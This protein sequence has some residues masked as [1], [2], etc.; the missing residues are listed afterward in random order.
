MLTAQVAR[1]D[2]PIWLEGL[3]SVSAF[4]TV[5]V[6]TQISGQ[7][8]QIGF[9]EG[10]MVKAGDF[11]AQIDPRPYQTA[12]EQME[13]QLLRDQALLNNAQLDAARYRRLFQQDSVA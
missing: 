3:G 8:V 5:T 13:G 7:L 6:K 10:Q 4:Y 1:R 2:V 11:L 9:Q 12:L